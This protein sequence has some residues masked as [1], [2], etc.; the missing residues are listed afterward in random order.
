MAISLAVFIAL[1]TTSFVF[2]ES[3]ASDSPDVDTEAEQVEDDSDES[4]T[5]PA[6]ETGED[7]SGDPED[8]V[9]DESADTSEDNPVDETPADEDGDESEDPSQPDESETGDGTESPPLENGSQDP[10]SEEPEEQE[11]SEENP[12]VEET[13]TEEPGSAPEVAQE[14]E[15]PVEVDE[16]VS[17]EDQPSDENDAQV[18]LSDENGEP[19]DMASQESADAVSTGDPWWISDG[20]K[21]AVVFNE[22]DCPS[23]T[24]YGSTCWANEKPIE[25]ALSLIDGNN[26]VPTDGKLYVEEGDYTDDV[27]IDGS[28][29]NGNLSG[30]KG[31]I[32]SGS[33]VVTLTG[34]INISNTTSG[35]TLSG[36]TVNGSISLDNNSGSLTL[37]DL[38]ISNDS[39]DGLNVTNQN[40]SVYLSNVQS[41]GNK[42][43]GANI[44]N[45]ASSSAS[46]TIKNSSFDFNDDENDSTW[47]VGLNIKTNGPVTLEG[48][49]ASRNNGSGAL[50]SG[51]SALTVNNS[52]FDH[53][54]MDP[55]SSTTPYGFGLWAS[56]SREAAVRLENVYAY[57]NDN[58]AI[59]IVTEGSVVLVNVRA[60]H[61][62]IRVGEIDPSGETVYER[63][64]EDNKYTGDR[65]YF[66]GTTDQ[67]LEILL[68]SDAFDAY[69]ELYDA[70]DDSLL[71]S[72][73]NID[74]ET[75]NSQINFTLLAD[76]NY[77]IVV[78]TLESS[79]SGDG[80]YTLAINDASH[81]NETS[82]DNPG[83]SVDTTSGSGSIVIY[84]G[85]FQD[86]IGDG[87][88]LDTLKNI[89]LKSIDASYNSGNGAVLDNCQYDDDLGVCLGYGSVL[90]YSSSSAS[91][92]E[93]NYFL[94][95]GGSGIVINTR[96]TTT[97]RN[98]SAYDN[99][100]NGLEL[101]NLYTTKPVVI[102]VTLSNFT[103]V[104]NSN[105]LSGVVIDARG[106]ILIYDTE[107]NLNDANGFDLS[108]ESTIGLY[109]IS[110]SGNGDVGL[111]IQDHD[112]YEGIYIKNKISNGQGE[113]NDN[114]GNGIDITSLGS[115]TI[116]NISASNN[117]GSGMVLDT[118]VLDGL[119]C[120]G[121]G[122]I[123]LKTYYGQENVFDDNAE[124]GLDLT[125]SG[126][127]TLYYLSASGNGDTGVLI[128]T[129]WSSASIAI[130][131][132]YKSGVA[133]YT[134]NG[135][136][137]INI[138]S[139]G[140]ISLYNVNSSSN[141][142]SG[143]VLDNCQLFAGTCLGFGA[144]T[145][146]GY[147]YQM[148]EFNN[149]HD[150][151]LHIQSS[152][153]ITLYNIQADGNG[154]NGLYANNSLEASIEPVILSVLKS[155]TN[156]FNYNGS[157][158]QG[159]YPGIEI[160]SY[161]Y[162][163]INKTEALNNYAAGAYLDNHDAPIIPAYMRI[164]NS[165][166]SENQGSGLIAYSD[167]T[168]YANNLTAS[169]NSLTS[170]DIVL[171][172]ETVHERLTSI[173]EYDTWWF[174]I[175][176]E[177]TI[178]DFLIILEST[179]FD[180]LL[181]LYDA[182]GNLLATDDNSYSEVDA[183]IEINLTE[184][185]FYYIRVLA[186]DG[187]HGNYTLAIND[188][189]HAYNTYFN[190]YG[191][192]LD[193]S[194]GS[195]NVYIDKSK[196]KSKTLYYSEFN[197]NAYR[198]LEVNSMG[199]ILAYN[200][201]ASDNGDT[202]AYFTNKDG[203]GSLTIQML[204][205]GDVGQ[206]NN[207][208]EWGIYAASRGNITLYNVSANS[209]GSAGALLNN[210]IFDGEN[211]QGDGN[212]YVKVLR[213]V[214]EFSGNN[215]YGLYI[216][217]SGSVLLYD[218]EANSNGYGGLY[219]KNQYPGVEGYVMLKNSKGHTSSFSGNG[220]LNPQDVFSVE[221][222]SNGTIKLYA[223]DVIANY[224]G[225]MLLQNESAPE[226]RNIYLYETNI[227]ANQGD[228]I[229]AESQG[230]IY[231][232]GVQSRY[233]SINSGEI[234]IEGESIFEHL[235]PY[236]QSD[237]WWFYGEGEV[238]II[239]ESSEFDVLLQVFDKDGTL[240]A[241]DDD[242]YGDTDARLTFTLP[243]YD[244]YY[245]LVSGN[246]EG[247]G[248]YTL[249]LNDAAMEN[250]T[251]YRIYGAMLDNS[252]GNGSN[253]YVKSSKILQ[254]PSFYHNNYTGLEIISSGY[255]YLY[256]L[257]A[258]KNGEDGI[259][260]DNTSGNESV[261]LYST[262]KTYSGSF[263][264]NTK[265]G[266]YIESNGS[267]SIKNTNGRLFLRDNGYSGAYIDN[268][269]GS[270]AGVT[271]ID[272]ELNQ[273]GLKGLEIHSSG[274]VMVS[275]IMAV[276]NESNGVYIQNDYD[277]N[278]GYVKVLGSSDMSNISDN[279]ATGLAIYS[280]GAIVVD[281]INAIQNSGRGMILSNES[282]L[283]KIT[284]TDSITRLNARHGLQI[285]ASDEVYLKNVHSMSNGEGYEGDGLWIEIPDASALTI[286]RSSF[287][288]N[289]GS[290]ID[291]GSDYLGTP[292]LSSVSYFGNDTNM[293]GDYNYYAHYIV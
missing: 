61:T 153:S 154:Y 34:S 216:S 73:D 172:G 100:G 253:V 193:N 239:L 148:N 107:A 134:Y 167:G 42:G 86:N 139:K 123:Y 114:G 133:D 12:E 227:E 9:P 195:A 35:F 126:S 212:V 64:S 4:S 103:N 115:I 257:S 57:Y 191:A 7:S 68:E 51:F 149:N 98:I 150:Y 224:G 58:T 159:T 91:W 122:R 165:E 142:G 124:Y 120:S 8:D 119:S 102:E 177:T 45:T 49:A 135:G 207:N 37:K 210:C 183:E 256:N 274:I 36:F 157:N 240:I 82:F 117:G 92:Y 109:R 55:F 28:S 237:T 108:S 291:L 156:S 278:T 145:V 267:V 221:V 189:S 236:Y 169:Y 152:D 219:V 85:M 284:V 211:C 231:L 144:I 285:Y 128:D 101:L 192:L 266:L 25:Y 271:V 245:I 79:G 277:G 225:G 261:V 242:S 186:A 214:N 188:E 194:S 283:G 220:W 197:E 140:S 77:Y 292:T 87:M 190:S 94:G 127:V 53:N 118:C 125:S 24:I 66:S 46:V 263:S 70:S 164:Y 18:V 180:A 217:S 15:T 158:V 106:D 275:D 136:D 184:I 162:I 176:E 69:L 262:S 249:S 17:A 29:G 241:V 116:Y 223:S 75:T 52:L 11:S 44:D 111:L 54:F 264:Y 248:N 81:A 1:M 41:R 160:Y 132:Y 33:G 187:D 3:D 22:G 5:P 78:K 141:A 255:V 20:V 121:T 282:G 175:T 2:A 198:G 289:E 161:G 286:Y 226:V 182:E 200:I 131:N 72:N 185:G 229:W 232:Y 60:S 265:F 38:Y 27:I 179:E 244:N 209:N 47:N 293:S 230:M 138:S 272:A 171:E 243:A 40:G 281:N 96:S 59:D 129:T 218:I 273:N 71:A 254:N 43:D 196:K 32:G 247:S 166:F 199:S 31:L 270:N 104:F 88:V 168:I 99:Q 50:I 39:G 80:D 56:T 173:S 228:G 110:A 268:S 279:G 259:N 203:S 252:Y 89:K 137:G 6:V 205:K 251:L 26:L 238:D 163:Y 178:T 260:V 95:N 67:V 208:S 76:G 147:N 288:G 280:N 213:A 48:I 21:Y 65:W 202:G 112:S 246:N 90:I 16:E 151:G 62:S 215:L 174:E 93:A 10:E 170:S 233:N 19:L 83:L 290:G 201:D 204:K 113:F 269:G 130:K 23:D 276:N 287:I 250:P 97:I 155:N 146:K 181:E 74:G 206:Y 63:L 235:T 222:V 13:E 14:V 258:M 30:L 105:G 234:D 143:V 84:G